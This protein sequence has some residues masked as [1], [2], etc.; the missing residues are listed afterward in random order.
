MGILQVFGSFYQPVPTGAA[1]EPGHLFWVPTPNVDEVPRI[2][3]VE[4]ATPTEH[5]ITG[6][7]IC[8][9]AKHH[10]SRRERL[11]IKRL[12]LGDTEELLIAKAKKRLVVILISI[13][14]DGIGTLPDG[15]QRRLAK[16]LEKP[17]YL[18]APLYS[19]SSIMEPGTFGPILVARI[20]ALQYLHFFCL[21][22]ENHPDRPRSIVRLDRVFPTYLGRGSE[23]AGEKIH[24]EPFEI[25]LS[26]LSILS[27]AVYREPYD[28]AREL[29]QDALPAD[30]DT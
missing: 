30:L 11:P 7:E 25:I 13:A 27:G 24:E 6:Y 1:P 9:I 4:R 21:P 28:L 17:S 23:P 5:E 3:D 20:R 2:L 26:Q 12:T 22:D 29:V 15:T 19:T 10:F 16:H 14:S 18:V 8:E